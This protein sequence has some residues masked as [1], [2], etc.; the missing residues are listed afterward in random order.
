MHF[1]KPIEK[2]WFRLGTGRPSHGLEGL[3]NLSEAQ[4]WTDIKVDL[5]ESMI[6]NMEKKKRRKGTGI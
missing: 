3:L 6:I 5:Y 1:P 2:R 4:Y